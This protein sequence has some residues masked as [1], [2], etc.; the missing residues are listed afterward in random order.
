[1]KQYIQY[2]VYTYQHSLCEDFKS[3]SSLL[4]FYLSL[5]DVKQLLF[6]YDYYAQG[7]IKVCSKKDFIR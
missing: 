3:T 5:G 1:M 2:I 6:S 4:S 7:N